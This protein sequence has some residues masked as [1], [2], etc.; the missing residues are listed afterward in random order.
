[1]RKLSL[2]KIWKTSVSC[3]TWKKLGN[4]HSGHHKNK[5]EQTENLQ[6]FLESSKN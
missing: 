1:M 5:A 3:Y 2:G 4:Q 6:L